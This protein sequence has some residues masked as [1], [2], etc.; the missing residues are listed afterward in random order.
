MARHTAAVLLAG[1]LLAGCHTPPPQSMV[2]SAQGLWSG[3]LGLQVDDPLAQ[4]QSFS[5]SFQLQGSAKQGSLDIFSPLGAQLA[6]LEWQAGA[7]Q[8]RQGH[9]VTHSNSLQ[10]LL[11]LSLGTALPVEA[12]FSW[13]EGQPADAP[14]W[15]VD[16][17][18]H[19]NGRITAQRSDPL[20]QTLL[21][22][23]LH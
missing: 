18:R 6:K 13:L 5:A 17:S 19:A 8:L 16:L 15:S 14:G 3:R 22:V 10:E 12:L 11:Q 21:R 23:I 2:P 4:A 1:F 9:Q 20:P 7:A